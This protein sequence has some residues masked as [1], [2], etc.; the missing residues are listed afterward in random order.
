MNEVDAAFRGDGTREQRLSGAGRAVQQHALWRE[1]A[2]AL[3]D[4]RVLERQLDHLAHPRHLA[5]QP[6]DVLVGHRRRARL[7]LLAL[8]DRMSVR[9]PMTTVPDGIVRTT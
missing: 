1:D 5:L 4:A 8:D 6:A 9:R 7:G 3:E 2:E